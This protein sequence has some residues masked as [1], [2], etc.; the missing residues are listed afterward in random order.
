MKRIYVIDDHSSSK[1]N[2]IG[3]F[4]RLLPYCF[5]GAGRLCMIAFNDDVTFIETESK[6]G[7]DYLRIPRF[8]DG[9]FL[10]RSETS[11]TLLRIHI[12]D[13]EENV[14]MVNHFPCA[15]LL[16]GLRKYFPLSKIVFVVHDQ[17]WTASLMGNFRLFREIAASDASDGRFRQYGAVKRR[18]EEEREMYRLA[19][20]VV[21]LAPDTTDLLQSA[22]GVPKEKIHEISNGLDIDA[23][24]AERQETRRQLLIAD[25][26]RVIIYAGRT[27][28]AKGVSVILQ[29]FNR[30]CRLHPEVKLVIAGEVFRLNEFARMSS[31]SL[32]RIVYTGL[33]PKERLYQWYSIADLGLLCSF[34][35][36]CSFTGIE[37]MAHRL[38]VVAGNAW[39]VRNMFTGGLNAFVADMGDSIKAYEENLLATLRSALEVDRALLAEM[40]LRAFETYRCKYSAANM[41]KGY[42][43]LI[44]SL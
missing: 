40:G 11:I 31:D 5:R 1:Q 34:S 41:R 28:D 16:E 35:D 23:S 17:S 13:S 43:E 14:F 9:S 2:G 25:E 26:E 12:A 29:T 33:I 15:R 18:C 24:A 44:R 8:A 32:S 4:M 38:P 20:A 19:D 30:L 10:S 37:M 39:C 7:A 27:T 21:S 22:Y 36:Q 42:L 3:T 6:D